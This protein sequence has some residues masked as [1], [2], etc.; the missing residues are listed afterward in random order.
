M[1]KESTL[2][3]V[4]F[5]KSTIT[6]ETSSSTIPQYPWETASSSGVCFLLFLMSISAWP[7]SISAFVTVKWPLRAERWRAAKPSSFFTS[8]SWRALLIVRSMA[9]H[10]RQWKIGSFMLEKWLD[11]CRWTTACQL[12]SGFLSVRRD[13]TRWTHGCSWAWS[14]HLE[15]LWDS[16][17]Y[18]GGLF[19]WHHAGQ[20]LRTSPE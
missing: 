17:W 16:R 20:C 2:W 10:S 14:P 4:C 6:F 11:F 13:A 1:N 7:C 18:H 12:T 19:L 3:V 15:C 9:L 5:D 8:T